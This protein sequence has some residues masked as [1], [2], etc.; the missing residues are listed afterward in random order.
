MYDPNSKIHFIVEA[1]KRFPAS[2]ATDGH[3]PWIHRYLYRDN[4]ETSMRT[5]LTTS[6]LYSNMNDNTKASVLRILFQS[7][8]ELK[9]SHQPNTPRGRL[10]RT[11]ALFLYQIM[12]LFDGDI[13]LR[14][15]AEKD[16][17]ILVDW[18]GDLCKVRDNLEAPPAA[19]DRERQGDGLSS[20]EVSL[21]DEESLYCSVYLLT[22]S[23]S[24]GYLL[25]RFDEPS[26]WLIHSLQSGQ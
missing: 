23:Y 14:A 3:T 16:M 25:S 20:W 13:T 7:P 15:Q 19:G 4:M 21:S 26:S 5:C 11:Q 24:D 8:A 6:S 9:Q 18:L 10:A 12:C 17:P 2:F 1:I 22:G